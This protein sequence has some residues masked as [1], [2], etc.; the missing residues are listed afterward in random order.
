MR[1]PTYSP[2]LVGAVLRL[3]EEYPGSRK[4]KLVILLRRGKFASS[5]STVSRMLKKLEERGTLKKPP[6]DHISTRRSQ[7][8]RPSAVRKPKDYVAGEPGHIVDVAALYIRSLPHARTS[9]CTVASLID[10]ILY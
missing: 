8:Q 9:S 10:A 4:A 7:R 5:S 1:P 6:T 2:E 3:R